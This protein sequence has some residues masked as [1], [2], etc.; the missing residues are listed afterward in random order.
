MIII[1]VDSLLIFYTHIFYKN[2][3][4]LFLLLTYLSLSHLIIITLPASFC[5]KYFLQWKLTLA[6]CTYL[7]ICKNLPSHS[8]YVQIHIHTHNHAYKFRH[9]L[10]RGP[11]EPQF[12]NTISNAWVIFH[13]GRMPSASLNRPKSVFYG[14]TFRLFPIFHYD[15]QHCNDY[16]YG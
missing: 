2:K 12:Y 8:K 4:I 1:L 15:K 6:S 9:S 11:W 3:I 10:N 14:W 5:F 7:R 13:H 16:S